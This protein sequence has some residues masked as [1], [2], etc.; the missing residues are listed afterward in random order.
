MGG[1]GQQYQSPAAQEL[2][3]DVDDAG[4]VMA[5][6]GLQNPSGVWCHLNAVLQALFAVPVFARALGDV[7]GHAGLARRLGTL[8]QKLAKGRQNTA[9]STAGIRTELDRM[10]AASDPNEMPSHG[11]D[12]RMSWLEQ[13]TGMHPFMAAEYFDAQQDPHTTSSLL[14]EALF[15]SDGADSLRS[16]FTTDI[17]ITSRSGD[18]VDEFARDNSRVLVSV[19]ELHRLSDDLV[20]LAAGRASAHAERTVIRFPEGESHVETTD[21]EA[22]FP[23]VLMVHIGSTLREASPWGIPRRLSVNDG[24]RYELRSIVVRTGRGG[25]D[26]AL[27]CVGIHGR[28]RFNDGVVRTEEHPQWDEIVTERTRIAFY[29]RQ[30]EPIA[31]EVIE[32]EDA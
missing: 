16:L 19:P 1:R 2:G 17:T 11:G 27:L 12:S 5:I 23:P 32:R 30:S 24:T 28:R 21:I 9:L 22:V 7:S 10:A 4:G 15:R 29:E 25:R 31:D 6:R 8:R 26:G 18:I 3:V 20:A 14:L 13:M